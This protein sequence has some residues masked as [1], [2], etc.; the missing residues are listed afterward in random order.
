M[1]AGKKYWQMY[2]DLYPIMTEKG[3]GRF[4]QMF[5]E[6]F[7]KAYERQVGEYQRHDRDGTANSASSEAANTTFDPTLTV[8]QRL[9][10]PVAVESAFEDGE[11]LDTMT[12]SG[13]LEIDQNFLEELDN[14]LAEEIS[15]DQLKA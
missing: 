14:T 2:R 3:D 9:D 8:T 12:K 15:R 6:E 11:V 4:P 13:A 1:L 5:G 10:V 7:V